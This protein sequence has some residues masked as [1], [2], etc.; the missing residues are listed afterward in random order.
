VVVVF[1]F[2]E[3]SYEVIVHF[4]DIGGIYVN[5]CLG[6]L[7]IIHEISKLV[8]MTRFRNNVVFHTCNKIVLIE[9]FNISLDVN[10]NTLAVD[11]TNW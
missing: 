6:F 7:F 9:F 10:L 8:R 3:C 2:S 1:L 4:V 11:Q 5:H